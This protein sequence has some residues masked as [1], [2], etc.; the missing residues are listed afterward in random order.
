MNQDKQGRAAGRAARLLRPVYFVLG[1]VCVAL[2]I[3]GAFLPLM[4]STIFLILAA[5]CF[6][7][8]S[9]RLEAWLLQHRRFGPILRAWR[10]E[11]AIP[12]RAKILACTGMTLGF[13][14]F[15][16]GA[17]PGPWLLAAV[18]LGLVACAAYVL[19]RPEPSR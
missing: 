7:R 17:Q 2:G 15:L 10:D 12:R 11:R 4:P 8:S 9:R 3:V 19:S 16:L 1:L 18:F 14:I 5:W 13:A 6:A